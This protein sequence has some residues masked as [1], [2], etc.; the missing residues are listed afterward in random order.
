MKKI[1]FLLTALSA[2]L[3][4]KPAEAVYEGYYI[5]GVGGANWM[6]YKHDLEFKTGYFVAMSVGY[7]FCNGFRLEGEVG[8]R[9]NRLRDVDLG[10]NIVYRSNAHLSTTSWMGHLF[11]E[12]PLHYCGFCLKPFV[13]AGIGYARSDFRIKS[14]GQ[15]IINQREI[16]K[17]F[18]WDVIAGVAYPICCNIDIDLE[19]RYFRT[20]YDSENHSLAAGVRYFF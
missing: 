18:A 12:Y 15:I 5:G 1:L 4:T 13:G 14:F 9:R 17:G 3:V 10:D 8:Y 16:E 20:R 2:L 6:N 11:Y 7:R 19:Y